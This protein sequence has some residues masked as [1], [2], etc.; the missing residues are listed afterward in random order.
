MQAAVDPNRSQRAALAARPDAQRLSRPMQMEGR[1]MGREGGTDLLVQGG[2]VLRNQSG[3]VLSCVATAANKPN[4]GRIQ[5][6]RGL[7]AAEAMRH[8]PVADFCMSAGDARAAWV[9]GIGLPCTAASS[10][11]RLAA[12]DEQR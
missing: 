3:W 2:Q 12:A 11:Q 10:M 6:F 4:F 5:F 7:F 1:L 8:Q 9:Q